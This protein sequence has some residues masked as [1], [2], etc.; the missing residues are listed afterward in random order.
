M[1]TT[2]ITEAQLQQQV[3]VGDLQCQRDPFMRQ[4]TSECIA[5]SEKPNKQG[6]YE[7]YLKDT[8]N[9]FYHDQM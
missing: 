3:P 6:L 1:S 4:F 2:T 9:T 8:S 7:V 5:C